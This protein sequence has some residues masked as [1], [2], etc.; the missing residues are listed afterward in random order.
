MRGSAGRVSKSVL[1]ISYFYPPMPGAGSVRPGRLAK[2]LP[3]LGWVPTTLTGPWR[4]AGSEYGEVV[5]L[6]PFGDPLAARIRGMWRLTPPARWLPGAIHAALSLAASRH[7]DAVVSISNPV[8]NHLVASIVARQSGLPWLADYSEAWTGNLFSPKKGIALPF[9]RLLETRSMRNAS[10][11]SCATPGISRLLSKLH[12]RHD[13]EIIENAVDFSE[14][15]RIPNLP[16]PKFTFL[17]AG[18]LWGGRL[19]PEILFAAV[20]KLRRAGHPAGAAA[21]FEFYCSEHRIVS[22]AARRLGVRDA[23]ILHDVTLR[24]HV[25]HAE[26]RAAALIILFPMRPISVVPSKLYEFYGA[27]RPILAIG[28]A[29]SK[30]ELGGLIEGNRLGHFATTESE[31]AAAICELYERFIDGVYE[32]DPNPQWS[33]P[34]AE[35]AAARFAGLLDRITGC[36]FPRAPAAVRDACANHK[37]C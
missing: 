7:F 27:R 30:A 12:G 26:R 11:M 4:G 14:W 2:M 1:L 36:P 10:A 17:F 25:L 33:P 15:E 6:T 21:R 31:C 5:A 18:M 37:T 32:T 24:E 3:Q 35:A 9:N 8:F 22:E 28:P 23:V 29:Q 13:V 16:P 34:T 19:S 20:A